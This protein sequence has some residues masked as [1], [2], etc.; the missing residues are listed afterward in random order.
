MRSY[1]AM[2][3]LQ[4]EMDDEGINA[5]VTAATE[6]ITSGEG[7]LTKSGQLADRKGSVAE[8]NEGWRTRR[9]MYPI[10]KR[11]EG[12]YVILEFNAPGATVETLEA[13]VRYNEDVLRHLVLRTDED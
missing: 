5:F 1:E 7:E 13:S 12:Y 8:I 2:F 6:V 11:K 9:L 4:P 3:I 10:K